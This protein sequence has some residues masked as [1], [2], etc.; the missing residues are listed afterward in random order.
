MLA[1]SACDM[2]G[3][4]APDARLDLQGVVDGV[5]LGDAGRVALTRFG[6]TNSR[7]VACGTSASW[8]GILYTEGPNAGLSVNL[9]EGP[10][11]SVDEMPIDYF[12]VT[13]PFQGTTQDGLGIGS[14]GRRLEEVLG[15]PTRVFR[16]ENSNGEQ[17]TYC[18]DS[19]VSFWLIDGAVS[20]ITMGYYSDHAGGSCR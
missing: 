10:A 11:R 2:S 1:V 3:S 19:E 4:D 14:T 20:S 5:R 7:S 12:Q 13:A 6:Q 15:A 18:L 9:L 16:P 8:H 17:R